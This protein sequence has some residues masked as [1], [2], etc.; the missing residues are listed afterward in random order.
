MDCPGSSFLVKNIPTFQKFLPE[1]TQRVC[2]LRKFEC[3]VRTFSRDLAEPTSSLFQWCDLLVH[4]LCYPDSFASTKTIVYR[5][6]YLRVPIETIVQ[7]VGTIV[8][9]FRSA[10][11][12]MCSMRDRDFLQTILRLSDTVY[13]DCACMAG[14]LGG[15]QLIIISL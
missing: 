5:P 12:K 2:R 1:R 10:V 4:Q 3:I 14:L 11:S 6:G 9:W 7:V 15:A 8:Q 13:L